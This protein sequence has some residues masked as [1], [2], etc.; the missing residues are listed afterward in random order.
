MQQERWA[1]FSLTDKKDADVYARRLVALGIKILSAGNTCKLLAEGGIPVMDLAELVGGGAILG[2]R[3]LS[4]SRE[5]YAGLLADTLSTDQMAELIALHLPFVDFVYCNF[6]DMP[7]AIAEAASMA[8]RMA[9]IAYVVEKTDVGGPSMVHAGAKGLR[10]VV[11]RKAD[12]D[13]VLCELE[14]NGDVS[15]A[16]RQTLRARAE[17]EVCRYIGHS[18]VF[19]SEGR[20]QIFAGERICE[21]KGENAPQSPAGLFSVGA[22]DPLALNNFKLVDGSPPSYNNWCDVDRLLQTMTH[23]AT[24]WMLNYGC[25]PKI[26]AAVKH[27]NVCGAMVNDSD[28]YISRTIKGDPRAVFGGL[29][30]TNFRVNEAMASIMAMSMPQ[31]KALFDGVIAPSFSEEAIEVLARKSGKCRIM[32]NPALQAGEL[33]LDKAPRFRYVRGGFLQQPNYTYVLDFKDPEMQVYGQR[34]HQAEK[35]LL[36]AW[37]VGATGNSNTVTITRNQMVIGNGTGRQDRVGGA[38]LAVKIA[39]DAGHSTNNWWRQ[40][41]YRFGLSKKAGLDGAVAYSDSF[42]PFED[43]V[44]VLIKAGVKAIFSTSGS[45][46]DKY[47]QELCVK[48]GVTLYQ[49]PDAKARGFFG[50]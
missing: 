39:V 22:I 14:T 34:N 49:L 17:Y 47:V 21:F 10:I 25:V 42:I 38:E 43:A 20:F 2:H 16:T 4:L 40:M 44:I 46:R 8:D 26:A 41:L 12:M 11:C 36:L 31:G 9:A 35:D 13:S 15:L 50:H 19:H 3:V 24:G 5:L 23:L 45:I 27:G 1:F 33:L 18:A 28:T 37:G 30:M 7:K 6:Y 29:I 48:H 32:V